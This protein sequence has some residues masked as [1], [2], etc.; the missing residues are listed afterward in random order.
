MKSS[1]KS[2]AAP[3]ATQAPAVT[4]SEQPVCEWGDPFTP[5]LAADMQCSAGNAAVSELVRG[6]QCVP[7]GQPG[8]SAPPYS[9]EA[10][11]RAEASRPKTGV[12]ALDAA[13]PAAEV[14]DAQVEAL[15]Q[16]LYREV[17]GT[18][19]AAVQAAWSRANSLRRAHPQDMNLA[20]AE[21]FLYACG[22]TEGLG[23][24]MQMQVL[25]LGYET[26]KFALD[27]FGLRDVL[28]TDDSTPTPPSASVLGWGMRGAT[29]TCGD[30]E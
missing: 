13:H 25:T 16:D 9:A 15:I 18:G 28:S 4:S 21:H 26:V 1:A 12:A 3:V 23:S 8:E 11:A 2:K 19:R 17:G 20:A 29:K 5:E 10:L 7:G 27:I 14:T 22:E 30:L 6:D 24:G